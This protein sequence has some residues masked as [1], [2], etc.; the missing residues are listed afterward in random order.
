MVES[1]NVTRDAQK[2]VPIQFQWPFPHWI[3]TRRVTAE[4]IKLAKGPPATIHPY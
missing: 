3:V 2:H 1:N 4:S